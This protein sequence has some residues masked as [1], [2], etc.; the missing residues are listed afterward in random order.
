MDNTEPSLGQ[1]IGELSR[2][3]QLLSWV[4]ACAAVGD[5]AIAI[6]LLV[7]PSGRQLPSACFAVLSITGVC[8]LVGRRIRVGIRL[9]EA[10]IG[11]LLELR[12]RPSGQN[13]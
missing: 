13:A 12:P 2:L 3:H 9:L 4:I 10:R 6:R 7:P 8:I 1:L 5:L 11:V